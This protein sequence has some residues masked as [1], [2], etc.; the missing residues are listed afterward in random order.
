MS[1]TGNFARG[2][3]FS[4]TMSRD[5]GLYSRIVGGGNSGVRPSPGRP[6]C[7][8]PRC[9]RAGDGAGACVWAIARVETARAAAVRASGPR[10]FSVMLS[11]SI[12]GER[13]PGL[14]GSGRG[15][16]PLFFALV[17]A[18]LPQAFE[19]QEEDRSEIE[20]QELRE[21]EPA[22]HRE[23]ERPSRLGAG[24]ESERDRQR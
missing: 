9:W 1:I 12:G 14:R 20:S 11:S 17:R 10:F 21:D 8:C 2:R 18:P 7:T 16:R 13:S 4:G 3:G 19:R 24:A 23:T 22:D 15:E 5:L 6:P